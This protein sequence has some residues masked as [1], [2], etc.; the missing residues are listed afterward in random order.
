MLRR[1]KCGLL[2][3]VFGFALST[4]ARVEAAPIAG[5][6][7]F[8]GSIMPVADWA[9]VNSI[10]I[11]GDKATV[12]CAPFALCQGEFAVFNAAG[13]Y[14]NA[15]GAVYNDFTFGPL[16]GVPSVPLWDWAFGGYGFNLLSVTNITRAPNG[17]VLSG[18][19]TIFRTGANAAANGVDPTFANWSF[20]ASQSGAGEFTE[21][22]FGATNA[23]T[24][25]PDAGSSMILLGSGLLALRLV[26]RRFQA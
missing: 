6:I 17:V 13:P 14:S 12:L 24:A 4:A 1:L 9:T 26:R 7:G 19:G 18:T 22:R 11:E 10:N 23:S 21:F 5:T 15:S 20:D 8:G 16:P 25:V 2:L 3:A